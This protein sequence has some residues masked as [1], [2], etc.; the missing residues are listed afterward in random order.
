M[1]VRKRK[2]RASMRPVASSGIKTVA[3]AASRADAVN[4]RR[5]ETLSARLSKADPNAPATNP[6]C[7]DIVSHARPA[8][9]KLHALV[10]AG[11]TAEAENHTAM[12][13]NSA[14]ASSNSVRHF[15]KCIKIQN[16]NGAEL[17]VSDGGM[18]DSL[19]LKS[20]FRIPQFC[21]CLRHF[22]RFSL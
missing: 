22:R 17:R 7:T 20:A 16:R 15:D 19:S 10:R 14:S 8:S 3:R 9:L 13:S 12:P 18:K 21:V 11:T 6:I 1:P 5:D 2:S 4:S